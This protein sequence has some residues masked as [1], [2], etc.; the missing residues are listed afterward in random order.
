MFKKQAFKSLTLVFFF[1][2]IGVARAETRVGTV[3]INLVF[4]EYGKTKAAEA[5]MN[6]SKEAARKEFEERAAAYKKALEEI[7]KITA[8][9]DAPALSAEAKAQ[10][11]KEREAKIAALRNMEREISEFRQ[12]RE[13]QLQQQMQRV[14]EGILKEITDVV[15]EQVKSRGL[16]L[17]F[18][19]SGAS[20]NGFSPLLFS[21]ANTDF[22]A[23]V[24]ASL[25]KAAT[26][27]AASPAAT[28]K[29]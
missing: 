16:D 29:R 12:T 5:K 6:E 26:A 23:E 20:L 22:T 3:D 7:N 10:K 2:L 15:L 21:P 13:Q 25:N 9:L 24:A 1:A 8:Q 18:D 4:K 17:V 28:P 11:A 14:R 19:K 27:S